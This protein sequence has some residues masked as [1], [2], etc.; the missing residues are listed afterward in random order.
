MY[1]LRRFFAPIL[2]AMDCFSLQTVGCTG[3]RRGQTRP[4]QTRLELGQLGQKSL[5]K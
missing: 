4:D 2:D 5:E 3:L 1:L